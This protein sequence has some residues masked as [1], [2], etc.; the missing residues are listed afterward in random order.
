VADEGL[1]RRTVARR[2]DHRVDLEPGAVREHR[3]AVFET[4]ERLDDAH[5]AASDRI[6]KTD[7][8]NRDHAAA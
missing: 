8:E 3:S 2:R 1:E 6:H 5:A 7:V 4:L